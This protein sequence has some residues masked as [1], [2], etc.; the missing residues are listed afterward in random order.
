ML[1]GSGDVAIEMKELRELL[2]QLH[3]EAEVE[4]LL[5]RISPSSL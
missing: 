3:A 5:G 1:R 4:A 2:A